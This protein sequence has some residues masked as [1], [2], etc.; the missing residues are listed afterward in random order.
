MKK[1][2]QQGLWVE[3]PYCGEI[4]ELIEEDELGRKIYYCSR[5]DVEFTKEE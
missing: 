2:K 4:A 1:K 3:C 5:C